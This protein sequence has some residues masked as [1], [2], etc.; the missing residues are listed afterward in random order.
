MICALTLV[1]SYLTPNAEC[2][3]P[4]TV[5][6]DGKQVVF[7]VD[8]II[9][10]GRTLVPMRFIFVALG[11]INA[12]KIIEYGRIGEFI[13]EKYSSFE[14]EIGHK[15]LNGNTNRV[16]LFDYAVSLGSTKEPI[17]GRQEYLNGVINSVFLWCYINC[18]IISINNHSGFCPRRFLN[19]FNQS[20]V[21]RYVF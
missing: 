6:V 20:I 17:S 16:E 13:K 3:K 19:K 15:I 2:E 10:N 21:N 18:F 1:F 11:L 4:V 14:S 9:E 7:D 12:A 8:P 5:F